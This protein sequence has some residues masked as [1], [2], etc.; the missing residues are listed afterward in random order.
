MALWVVSDF[1]LA[2]ATV[3]PMFHESRQ[4]KAIVSLCERIGA[5]RDGELV[6]L[7]DVFDLTGMAPP[8]RGLSKFGRKMGISL[9]DRPVRSPI[10][11]CTAA[12]PLHGA[13]LHALAEL[14]KHR[15]ITLVPGNHDH[16][17]GDVDG[18]AALDAAGLERIELAPQVVRT[19]AD[20]TVVMQ[21]G[22]ELDDDNAQAGG[23]GEAL[24]QVV[25]HAVVPMLEKLPIRANVR[26]DPGRIVL[27][28]PEER[29]VPVLERWLRPDQFSRFVDALLDLMVDVG[30]LS[31]IEAWLATPERLRS[32]LKNADDLWE[33]TGKRARAVL[34]GT[35]PS[36]RPSPRADLLVLGHTHV[37]DWSLEDCD[38]GERLYVNLGSWTDRA[39]DAVGP[40][41]D[42]LPMLRIGDDARGLR[43][44]LE[45]LASGEVLQ[46]FDEAHVSGRAA[47]ALP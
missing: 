34:A 25:H 45:E 36:I 35:K 43:A 30:A 28:R 2:D 41:D 32:K 46:S 15:K 38:G 7:G 24:T 4:G 8:I 22:H 11:L 1:H 29:V 13:T 44:T 5:E 26:I 31:R 19:I 39:T 33:D 16:A 14:S 3:L 20:R 40:Y 12:R 27:L 23:S 9:D 37:P 6:L 47:A 21:H 42:T 18:R 10:E 17:F